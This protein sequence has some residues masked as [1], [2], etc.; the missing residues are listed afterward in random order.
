MITIN[1]YHRVF[2]IQYGQGTGTAFTI[3]VEQ[4]QYLITAR[5]L[6]QGLSSPGI[7]K[8]FRKNQWNNIQVQPI[9]CSD[10]SVDIAVLVPPQQLSPS[11]PL[12]PTS[13]G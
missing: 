7:I 12:E 6:V 1:V 3:D 9:W 2:H 13:V 10:S 5:H 8:L 4:R 11:F